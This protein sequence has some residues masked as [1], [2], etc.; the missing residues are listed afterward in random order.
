M[1]LFS[2]ILHRVGSYK[3]LSYDSL[4]YNHVIKC[5]ITHLERKGFSIIRSWRITDHILKYGGS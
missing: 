4:L 5:Y 2:K 1:E 3:W